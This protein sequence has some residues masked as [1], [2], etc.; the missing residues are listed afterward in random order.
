[1]I[2]PKRLLP[3]WTIWI[4][5]PS[6][7]LLWLV[8]HR[9]ENAII[10]LSSLWYKIKFWKNSKIISDY[11]AWDISQRVAD[12]EEMFLDDEVQ[13][14][15]CAIWWFHSNQII[16]HINYDIIRKNP[17]I[18]IGFSDISVLHFAF[19][20]QTWLTTF[21]GPAF[22]TQ[23]W[24]KSW[25]DKYTIEHFNKAISFHENIWTIKS[26][27]E[28]TDE[29]L[30]RFSKED[31]VRPRNMRKNTW[32][33]RLKSWHGEWILLWGC[34][35]SILHLRGTKYWPDFTNKIFFWEIPESP[36]D[37]KKWESYSRIDSHLTD[38]FLSWVFDN[39]NWMIIGRPKWYSE[40]DIEKLKEIIKNFFKDYSFPI[41]FNTDIWHT[42][43]IATYPL[44]VKCTIDSD[45]NI[46]SIDESWVL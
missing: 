38:L 25:I 28:R 19:Y 24:D 13:M 17:K 1:M 11:T 46:F 32:Y 40:Q 44:W 30:N 34:I 14:I 22:L 5:S 7:P 18:F 27:E 6:S 4:I 37:L 26:S 36:S 12:I 45:Q 39:L 41:L 10:N 20:T 31:L 23:F 43:P 9:V 2:K 15:M 16:H 21:Y 3:G 42:D 33:K 29:V 35:T 8:P